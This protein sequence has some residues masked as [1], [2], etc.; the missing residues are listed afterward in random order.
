MDD[1]EPSLIEGY[2]LC[3]LNSEAVRSQ[4]SQWKRKLLFFMSGVC[5]EIAALPFLS[6]FLGYDFSWAAWLLTAAFL[7][8]GTLGFFTSKFGSERFVEFL[9]LAPKFTGKA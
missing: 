4:T 8:L 7:P 1:F 9:L 3:L 5:I 6:A 2:L